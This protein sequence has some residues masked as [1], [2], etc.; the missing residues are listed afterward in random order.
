MKKNNEKLIQRLKK[1]EE[2]LFESLSSILNDKKI[3][4]LNK[5]IETSEQ[6]VRL[7]I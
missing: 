5:L 7:E 2:K 6:I 4:I 3:K 1:K